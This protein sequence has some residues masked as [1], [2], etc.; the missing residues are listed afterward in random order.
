MEVLQIFAGILGMLLLAAFYLLFQQY[1]QRRDLEAELLR[2]SKV[3][4]D[5]EIKVHEMAHEKFEQFKDTV[6]Q[7]EQQR[8]AAEQSVVAQANFERWKIEYEGIIRQDAIKKSQAV[9]IGKVTE[10]IIPFFGGI[11]PY[12]PKEARFIGSPV[13]LIVFNNMETD[14]DS[15]SVHFIEV[16]T[17]G[18]T[19]TPKQRAIKYAILNKRVEWKELRI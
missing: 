19:L 10:H 3:L 1:K 6:L 18:S 11:F 14:L 12:N 2:Q 15:I 4:S 9:T 16:K 13:D 7:V 5:L 17:A 8:I